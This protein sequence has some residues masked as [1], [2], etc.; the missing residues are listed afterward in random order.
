MI[1]YN[2]NTYTTYITYNTIYYSTNN[3]S[4][5]TTYNIYKNN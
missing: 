5:Y 3:S 4:I 2:T 1:F